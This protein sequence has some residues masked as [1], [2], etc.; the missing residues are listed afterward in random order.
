MMP[1]KIPNAN[2]RTY[3]AGTAGELDVIHYLTDDGHETMMT[4]WLPSEE[5]RAK[6]AAGQ[7]IFLHIVGNRH[8]WVR[9]ET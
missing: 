7:P 1:I 4:A 8:P 5:D 9:L 3:E 2:T 6:I